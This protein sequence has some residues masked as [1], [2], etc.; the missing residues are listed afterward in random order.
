[1]NCKSCKHYD[2]GWDGICKLHPNTPLSPSPHVAPKMI[3]NGV[4]YINKND[5]A[6]SKLKHLRYGQPNKLHPEFRGK[7]VKDILLTYK[8]YD[9]DHDYLIITFTD[10][11][12]LSFGIDHA[13]KDDVEFN[14]LG[15]AYMHDEATW[16]RIAGGH[17]YKDDKT[18]EYKLYD[19]MQV[20]IDIGL[21]NFT[22]EDIRQ[23]KEK[24][25]K[26]SE[27]REYQYYLRLKE[28]FE[29]K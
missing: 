16:K 1:M 15:E 26:E 6:K 28:K 7:V 19:Y 27:D 14:R 18:G 8:A 23:A 13:E 10:N 9:D 22:S 20:L 5:N 29:N 24:R 21:Y 11:T 25:D 2:N 12:Y 17:M 3:C 4:E